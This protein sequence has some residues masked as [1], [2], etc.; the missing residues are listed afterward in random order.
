M[1]RDDNTVAN[2]V[3]STVSG[4]VIGVASGVTTVAVKGGTV[5]YNEARIQGS[6]LYD[7]ITSKTKSAQQLA[8]EKAARRALHDQIANNQNRR[9][10][11]DKAQKTPGTTAQQ[12]LYTRF[13]EMI[14]PQ[15]DRIENSIQELN[16]GMLSYFNKG[17]VA[18]RLEEKKFLNELLG[19][20]TLAALRFLVIEKM[21]DP[22]KK[23]N[24]TP[25][26]S[27]LYKDILNP[28][29]E[30]IILRL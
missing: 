29:H 16:K 1:Q 19:A 8:K 6:N 15:I 18:V 11:Y 3:A 25:E 2:V 24:C 10:E 26:V 20:K 7:A 12:I 4:V 14:E 30:K 22:D 28:D 27:A 17:Q 5:V 9:N 23:D 13:H 21:N